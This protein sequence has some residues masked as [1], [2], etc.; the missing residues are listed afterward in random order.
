MINVNATLKLRYEQ[1]KKKFEV[2]AHVSVRI[3]NI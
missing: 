3:A 2:L 1:K